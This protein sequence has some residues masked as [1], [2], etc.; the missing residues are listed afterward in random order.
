MDASNPNATN[1][2]EYINA[3]ASWRTDLYSAKG[4]LMTHKESIELFKHH[5]VKMTPE[6]K[7]PN[8]KMPYQG[9]Y[10][11]QGYAQQM[12]NQ[13]HQAKVSAKNVNVNNKL[14]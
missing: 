14:Y 4:T 1:V 9:T 11:Q 10:T 5:G 2:T 3:T 8:V 13:Y 6:L 12:I 7:S